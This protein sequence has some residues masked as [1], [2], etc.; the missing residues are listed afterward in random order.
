MRSNLILGLPSSLLL[1]LAAQAEGQQ[2]QRRSPTA[3]RKM[4]LDSSEKL[5]PEH[6]AF[7]DNLPDEEN[8]HNPFLSPREAVLAARLQLTAE[9]E[10]QLNSNS[11]TPGPQRQFRP[12]FKS[13]GQDDTLGDDGW[14]YHRRARDTLHLL[15]GRQGCPGGFQDCSDVGHPNKC[16]MT[17]EVCVEVDDSSVGGVAC[18]PE[19]AECGGSVGSCPGE[20]TTCDQELGGGCCIEGYICEGVGCKSWSHL[21]VGG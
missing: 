20:A 10:G 16:C 15:E 13:H 9:E 18:C 1:L 19:G 4:P 3:I 21:Y 6:L 2:P 8:I 14:W 17:S 12:A 7:A 11:S 5:F